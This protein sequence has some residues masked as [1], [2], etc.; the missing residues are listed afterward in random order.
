MNTITQQSDP[1]ATT[2]DLSGLNSDQIINIDDSYDQTTGT[3]TE[4]E[5]QKA[6]EGEVYFQRL[7]WKRLAVI[8]VVEAIGLGEFSL[9]GAFATLGVI[10]GVFY[11]ISLGLMAV[12]TVWIIGK[13][14]VL[15]PA[16]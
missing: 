12:Y 13:V 16:I 15:F 4:F 10:A 1:L 8:L 2:K 9:L 6:A 5:K 11:C 3:I 7:G 14:T